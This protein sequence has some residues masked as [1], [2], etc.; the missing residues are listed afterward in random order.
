MLLQQQGRLGDAQALLHAALAACPLTNVALS[1]RI[2]DL[3]LEAERELQVTPT[4]SRTA[5]EVEQLSEVATPVAVAGAAA[6]SAASTP[7]AADGG[8]ESSAGP[9][10]GAD[11]APPPREL[12]RAAVEALGAGQERRASLLLQQAQQAC[13]EHNMVDRRRI[14]LYQQMI[15]C[16]KTA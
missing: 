4:H 10:A 6:P 1:S 8:S 9:P 5:S 3:V 7:R 13:T 15:T 12:L 16:K 2:I 14:E 11:A